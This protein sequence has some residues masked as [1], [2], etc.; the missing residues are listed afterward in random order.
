M[1]PLQ[2][3][4]LMSSLLALR[5]EDGSIKSLVVSQFTRFLTLLEVPLRCSVIYLFLLQMMVKV[6]P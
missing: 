2:V 1:S 6:S 5:S 3:T 4:A